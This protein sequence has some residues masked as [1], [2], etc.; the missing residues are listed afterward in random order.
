MRVLS[1]RSVTTRAA[2]AG[3]LVALVGAP[4]FRV[5][6]AEASDKEL[7]DAL[8]AGGFV[9]VLRHGATLPDKVEMEA[10]RPDDM[11]AQRQLNDKGKAQ[12][13]AFGDAL[14]QI[15][16]PIDAVY[17]SLLDR[18]YDTA[19]LAGF[20]IIAKTADLAE[21]GSAM[22]PD[23]ETRRAAAFRKLLATPP[24]PG[25]NTVLVTHK[26]NIVDALGKDWS[27]VREGEASIFHPENGTAT[28]VARVQM[29]D[30]PRMVAAK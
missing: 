26:P 13:K 24:K 6:P 30:W 29:E 18:A 8:R 25:T 17:T 19:R 10:V 5:V 27:D 14:R 1:R 21:G 23:E 3:L 20:T 11:T 2:W 16:V 15:G 7:A 22:S 28:L 4:L 12:A 9:I